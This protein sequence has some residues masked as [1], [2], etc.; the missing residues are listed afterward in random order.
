MKYI[1]YHGSCYDGFGAAYAA[2]KKFGD[3][4]KYIAVS[5][6]KSI[7]DNHPLKEE[8]EVY[9]VDYSVPNDEFDDIASRVSRLVL[10]DHHKTALERF[11]DPL[12]I[13]DDGIFI[14]KNENVEV[15]FNMNKSGALITWE[16]FHPGTVVP[17]LV[18]FISDRDLWRFTFTATQPMHALLTSKEMNFGLWDSIMAEIEVDSSRLVGIG[19][20][21]LEMQAQI[22]SDICKKTYMTEIAGHV[23]PIVN[24]SSHWSE[25][26]NKLLILYPN[27]PFSA[28]YTDMPDGTR[29]YSLRS[30]ASFDVSEIALQFGGGGHKQA[31]GFKL[32]VTL[33]PEQLMLG[34]KS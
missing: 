25:I 15:I 18:Q 21:L 8:D 13:P 17:K 23:V 30:N 28:S 10:L 2:W 1:F 3:S 5:Y 14:H 27:A 11:I 16:Y 20:S 26:G 31:A 6:G 34:S 9:I 32:K 7:I 24:T 22:V 12:P 33:Q 4:A 29:M 19:N